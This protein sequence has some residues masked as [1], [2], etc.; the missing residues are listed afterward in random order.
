MKYS[1]PPL[2]VDNQI[3]LLISRGL[4]I[5][6]YDFAKRILSNISYYRLSN[7]FY[8]FWEDKINHIFYKNTTLE[9]IVNTY[10]F[11]KELRAVCFKAIEVIEISIRAKLSLFLSPKYGA[12]WFRNNDISQNQENFEKITI[13]IEALSK[14]NKE[15]F[16]KEHFAKYDDKH[17]PSW[18]LLEITSFGLL[19]RMYGNIK[20]S[21]SEKKAIA[22]SVA[23]PN[24][25]IL[26]SWLK[27]ISNIRNI[28][29]HH[30][31]L[32]DK[33]L[34]TPIMIPNKLSNTWISSEA[35]ADIKNNKLYIALCCI[36]YLLNNIQ[37]DNNFANN[38]I[39]IIKK[40][41]DIDLV[42]MNFPQN[43]EIEKFWIAK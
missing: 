41:P 6:D 35:I 22:K 33:T 34:S 38:I 2:N 3:K 20:N 24:H 7:Y 19:S 15:Q 42:K 9:D 18:K 21:I 40:Y 13:E 16:I 10:D 14:Q 12:Y 27:S 26:V 32:W 4:I 11:D 31:R 43:L 29:A 28:C 25:L 8:N 17:L 36:K 39:K 37:P 1:K 23:I 5:K 30:S